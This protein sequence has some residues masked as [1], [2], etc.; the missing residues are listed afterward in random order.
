MKCCHAEFALLVLLHRTYISLVKERTTNRKSVRSE[1]ERKDK[2]MFEALKTRISTWKRY[3]RTV[4]ELR[5]LSNRE[6][7]DLGIVRSE[8]E[9]V[10]REAVR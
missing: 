10:A 8:I 2:H 4:A 1:I 7:S 9:R 3:S 5:A 6:L